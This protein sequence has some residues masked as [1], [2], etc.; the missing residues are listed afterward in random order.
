MNRL[1]KG[2]VGGIALAASSFGSAAAMNYQCA[3]NSGQAIA[4][5]DWSGATVQLFDGEQVVFESKGFYNGYQ[6]ERV[7]ED[8]CAKGE[9]P[10]IA[11]SRSEG[12]MSD[13]TT[14][15]RTDSPEKSVVIREFLGS[16]V[17]TTTNGDQTTSQS[18][19]H[20]INTGE[21]LNKGLRACQYG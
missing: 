16:T 15:R 5:N 17:I 8:F 20:L 11:V 7:A 3:G 19:F 1:Q 10:P 4:T 13:E 21:A 9:K 6:A 12:W 18:V 2:L 14:C